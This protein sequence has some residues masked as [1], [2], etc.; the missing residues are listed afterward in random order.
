MVVW[1]GTKRFLSS[2]SEGFDVRAK[3]FKRID[4]GR[5]QQ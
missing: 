2:L 4:K 5:I 1:L 3:Q